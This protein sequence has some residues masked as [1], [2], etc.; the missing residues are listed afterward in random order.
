MLTLDEFIHELKN[1]DGV[2]RWP[3]MWGGILKRNGGGDLR[4]FNTTTFE[5]R[6]M[7]DSYEDAYDDYREVDAAFTMMPDKAV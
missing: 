3:W 7:F 2:L 4:V 1:L 6:A 5:T